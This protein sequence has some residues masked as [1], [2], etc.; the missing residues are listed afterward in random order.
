[1]VA[2]PVPVPAGTPAWVGGILVVGALVVF[3]LLLV[4]TIRAFRDNDDSDDDSA[5]GPNRGA[6][7]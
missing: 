5:D 4:R 7:R 6:E 1:M 2:Y 3:V